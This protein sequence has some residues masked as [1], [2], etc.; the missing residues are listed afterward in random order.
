[1][2][3]I[4]ALLTV[5]TVIALNTIA[6]ASVVAYFSYSTFNIPGKDPYV[7]T[8]ISVFG[9]TVRYKLNSNGKYQAEVEV[10]ML[11]LQHDSIKASQKYILSSPEIAD[12]SAKSMVNFIDQ[13]RIPLKQGLYKMEL[14]VA[15]KNNKQKPFVGNEEIV[16]SFPSNKIVFSDIELVES[17]SKATTQSSL[18]KN[19]I[20]I[21]PYCSNFFPGNLS[22]IGFYAES[23]NAKS[24]LGDSS[25]FV[26]NYFIESYE[27]KRMLAKFNKFSTQKSNPVNILLA[28]F[29][30]VDLPSGNYNLVIEVH[31]KAN[32]LIASRRAFFQRLNPNA[33][34]DPQ[35]LANIATSGTFVANFKS[36]DSLT[37]HV[38][39]LRPI[40]S[41]AEKIF[42]DEQIKTST[43]EMMQQYFYSAL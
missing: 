4:A 6:G 38:R 31:D 8:Y 17:Y 9:N 27:T 12:T 26:F 32:Q 5:Y 15:D 33:K 42:I 28:E 40:A 14:V 20:D 29:N 30:I 37:D 43:L 13:K 21:V 7:E 19:G 18:T 11:F 41:E 16:L 35:D 24:T 25:K 1:M 34:F 22:R 2:K 39:S 23:Y 36:K 3:K 10:S